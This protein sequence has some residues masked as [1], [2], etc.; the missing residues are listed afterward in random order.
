MPQDIIEVSRHGKYVRGSWSMAGGILYCL[1][2]ISVGGVSAQVDGQRTRSIDEPWRL[3]LDQ[4]PMEKRSLFDWGGWFRFSYWDSDDNV[5]RDGDGLKDYDPDSPSDG[6]HML[7]RYQLRLWGFLTLDDAHNFYVRGLNDYYDW[8]THTSYRGDDHYWDEAQLERGWY[9]FR[10]S[11]V[12]NVSPGDFDFSAQIGR[13]YVEMGT[14]LALSYPLDAV[15]LR[16]YYKDW[17]LTGLLAQSISSSYNI[18][19]SFPG[20]SKECRTYWGGELQY[21]GWKDHRPFAYFFAQNDHDAGA[22]RLVD[23]ADITSAQSFGYDSYYTG[24][25]SRG[26]FFHKDVQYTTEVVFEGGDSY[27]Q[28]PLNT[29]LVGRR[30]EIKAWAFDTELRYLSPGDNRTQ[31]IAEYLLTSGD[32]DRAGSPVN[33]VGGNRAGTDDK[34]FSAWGYRNTGISLAPL[35]S[36]LGMVRLGASTYP[37]TN[38]KTFEAMQ[39]GT[40]LFLF[41]KQ[42][43]TGAMS[44]GLSTDHSSWVGSELDLFINWRLTSDLAWSIYYGMFEPGDAFTDGHQR[45][46]FFTAVTLNF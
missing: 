36:N 19:R 37:L 1:L 23:P 22:I 18:D 4:L 32:G 9:H 6:R 26:R 21:N 7:R 46:V 13:Q 25:G 27:A 41:H 16:G 15:L 2:I 45:Q 20:D 17:Q 8:N 43:S 30:E 40:D 38:S 44:D 42:D 24:F 33:T 34:S 35:M 12:P 14:G 29:P 11:K 39:V 28:G 5:D 3:E 31:L 10:Y